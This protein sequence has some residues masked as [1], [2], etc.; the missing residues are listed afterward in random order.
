V[1]LANLELIEQEGLVA[2]AHVIGNWFRKGLEPARGLP[3]VGDIRGAGAMLGIE[4]VA[5][6]ATRQPLMAGGVVAEIRR[7]H[8][9]IVRDYGNTITIAPPL[10]ITESE[11]RRA[12]DAIVEVLSRTAASG[13]IAPS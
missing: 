2:R 6:K 1:A 11:V 13:D 4:L 5:D 10:V 8:R 7:A 9:V 3:V 12:A